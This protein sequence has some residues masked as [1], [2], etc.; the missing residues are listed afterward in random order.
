M[1]TQLLL[2]LEDT[3]VKK[4]IL[5]KC[6]WDPVYNVVFMLLCLDKMPF[7]MSVGWS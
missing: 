3:I 4:K 7:L 2:F 6:Q 1:H 5:Q